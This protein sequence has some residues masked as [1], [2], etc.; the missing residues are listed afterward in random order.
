M[1]STKYIKRPENYAKIVI[2]WCILSILMGITGGLLG[3]GFHHVLHF[4]TH[5]RSE[6]MWL[7]YLL[8]LGGLL[9]VVIYRHPKMKGNKGTNEIIEATLDG[10]PVSA[11]VAPTILTEE[12][13][14]EEARRARER[15]RNHQKY[16]RKKE[17][18][19]TLPHD[20]AA[21]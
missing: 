15:E 6:H 2:R 8:P 5:V 9:T 13:L 12:Q 19:K 17:R 21:A 11:L 20:Q 10:H 14:Q 18:N 7:I 16:L 3:A 4:V 1:A